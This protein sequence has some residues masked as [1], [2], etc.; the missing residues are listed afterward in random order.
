MPMHKLD[1]RTVLR[2]L[3]GVAVALPA[4]EIMGVSSPAH[5]AGNAPPRRF[6]VSYMGTS[7]GKDRKGDLIV[8]SRTGRGYPVPRSLK[9][10][11]ELGIVDDVSVVTNLMIPVQGQ[12]SP[13]SVMPPGGRIPATVHYKTWGTMLAG[14]HTE[15]TAYPTRSTADQ[16]AAAA[17]GGSKKV[18]TYL[19]VRSSYVS[20]EAKL[21]STA[22]SA[23][24]TSRGVTRQNCVNSPRLAYQ[25]LFGNFSPPSGDT[26]TADR[27]QR[28][29]D[30]RKS[31]LDLV[32]GDLER[33]IGR[34][35]Q[36]DRARMQQHLEE[37]RSLEKRLGV[38]APAP[39]AECTAPGDPGEDQPLGSR[40]SGEEK[41][42]DVFADIIGLAF[43]CDL[44]RSVLYAL[45]TPK[46]AGF[47]LPGWGF[48]THSL[49]HNL[50]TVEGQADALSWFIKQWGKVVV[51]LKGLREPD[52]SSL[53]D[54]SALTL[55]FE[56]GYGRD[57]DTGRTDA[58]HSTDNMVAL[59]AGRAGGLKPGQHVRTDRKHP[60]LVVA[61]ALNAV[62]V[63][64]DFGELKGN[65]A[66]L[67]T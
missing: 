8:P 32:G 12:D 60:G 36:A 4:L 67:F 61:S 31:V 49:T 30:H 54:H 24:A 64:G 59:I 37:V 17:L 29:L 11:V 44:S 41:N 43:A 25:G 18:G 13:A 26:A 66:D 20:G 27:L 3:G 65:I 21:E 7:T 14:T 63:T 52:G 2:G 9:S 55:V 22:Y 5:A 40:Y 57:P 35:G 19:L 10:L 42:A 53:L 62:G 15:K 28:L 16:I 39:A 38:T 6:L 34:L 50:G 33:L 58:A 1:R 45:S 56:G 46:C 23:I 47:S 48:A 51:K